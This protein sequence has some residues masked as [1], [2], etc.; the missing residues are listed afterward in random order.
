VSKLIKR[1][2]LH[3]LSYA[4][5]FAFYQF[6]VWAKACVPQPHS[7]RKRPCAATIFVGDRAGVAIHKDLRVGVARYRPPLFRLDAQSSATSIGN[8]VSRV[9]LNYVRGFLS[10]S[11]YEAVPAFSLSVLG[12]YHTRA[13]LWLGLDNAESLYRAL[14]ASP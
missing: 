1:A 9:F 10:G 5:R 8:S 12:F 6:R 14:A 4:P 3:Q 7:S 13:V 2:L 11:S